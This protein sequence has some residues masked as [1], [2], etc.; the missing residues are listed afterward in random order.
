MGTLVSVN[1]FIVER[2]TAGTARM[3]RGFGQD[4]WEEPA[5]T[6]II[7]ERPTG[8]VRARVS[9][10]STTM[11]LPEGHPRGVDATDD[12]IIRAVMGDEHIITGT[13]TFEE[14]GEVTD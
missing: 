8:A 9:L 1:R 11:C 10:N 6:A 4:C 3:S 14:V 13:P 12:Q 7:R 2:K 5:V